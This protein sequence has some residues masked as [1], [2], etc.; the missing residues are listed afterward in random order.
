MP[1]DP[2]ILKQAEELEK[3][4]EEAIK[5]GIKLSEKRDEIEDWKRRGGSFEKVITPM[6]PKPG[7]FVEGLDKLDE[8]IDYVEHKLPFYFAGHIAEEVKRKIQEMYLDGSIAREEQWIELADLTIKLRKNNPDLGKL[9]PA[10]LPATTITSKSPILVE[11][12]EMISKLEVS[13]PTKN[14]FDLGYNDL[15]IVKRAMA[16]EYGAE[17]K[18]FGKLS[19]GTIIRE[20]VKSVL[21]GVYEPIVWA[22]WRPLPRRAHLGPVVKHKKLA[23]KLVEK[24]RDEIK[25]D[26]NFEFEVDVENE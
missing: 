2:E 3:L 10:E 11:T 5:K 14:S 26:I 23:K 22:I 19:K 12:G 6:P 18:I 25:K 4:K 15:E 20:N 1:E 24:I 8:I 21:G 7:V 17:I 9:I 16:H 13:N